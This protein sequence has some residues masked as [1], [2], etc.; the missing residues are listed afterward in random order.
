MM[1][2]E[3]S[4]EE[5]Q[6]LHGNGECQHRLQ[7]VR[8]LLHR[9]IGQLFILERKYLHAIGSHPPHRTHPAGEPPLASETRPTLQSPNNHAFMS[10]KELC[11]TRE[12]L[13]WERRRQYPTPPEIEEDLPPTLQNQI[14]E[15]QQEFCAEDIMHAVRAQLYEQRLCYDSAENLLRVLG[16]DELPIHT[17]P[18]RH[19]S[20]YPLDDITPEE[21]GHFLFT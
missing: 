18:P 14:R 9:K 6:L 2:D 1:I 11:Q 16:H 19:S 21:E 20:E 13:R 10:S 3:L 17:I 7:R 4:H 8:H 5:D 15:S 12:D